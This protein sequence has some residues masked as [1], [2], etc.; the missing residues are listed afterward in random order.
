MIKSFHLARAF[1]LV[2]L[3]FAGL[4]ISASPPVTRAQRAA[5]AHAKALGEIVSTYDPAAWNRYRSEHFSAQMQKRP[6]RDHLQVFGDYWDR[7]RGLTFKSIQSRAPDEITALYQTRLTGDWEAVT[8]HVESQPP[9]R[10]T[11]VQWAPAQAP[12]AP[13]ATS[14]RR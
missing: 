14:P 2:G 5:E 7:S 3:L 13:N 4:A 6:S 9:Y 12:R 8:F 11:E 10:L 1:A